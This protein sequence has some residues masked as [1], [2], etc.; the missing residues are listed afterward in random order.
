[1]PLGVLF[2][3]LGNI[4]RSP[5]AQ[6]VFEHQVAAAGLDGRIVVDSCSTAAFN[7]GKAPDP[8]AIAAAAR[9]G[10]DIT[11]QVARQISDDDFQR[12]RYIVAMDRQNLMHVQT[13][14][15]A[16]YYGEIRLLMDYDMDNRGV[17]QIADPYY[18]DAGRFDSVIATIER[19]SAGLL[20]HIR[21]EHGL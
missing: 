20:A 5:S 4:C 3:C 8:R 7:V 18:D 16:D 2:V 6:G 15:P 10:Y 17:T 21:R 1:M 14:A 9:A 12:F 19:A 13:W 11:S